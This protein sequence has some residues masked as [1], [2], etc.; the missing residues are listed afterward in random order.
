MSA[1]VFSSDPMGVRQVARI[2]PASSSAVPSISVIPVSVSPA[3]IACATGAAPRQRGSSDAWTLIARP[4][5]RAS[6]APGMRLPYAAQMSTAGRSARTASSS[7]PRRRAGWSTVRPSSAARCATAERRIRPRWAG[8][9]GWVTTPARMIC[10]AAASATS[11]SSDGSANAGV[12]RKT[13]RGI[14]R[15]GCIATT[16]CAPSRRGC[17]RTASDAPRRDRPARR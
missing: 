6:S 11:A 4:S 9:S 10:P 16:S 3:R 15:T 2:A 1:P 14:V 7:T 13:T 12:P 17:A 5:T 8:R